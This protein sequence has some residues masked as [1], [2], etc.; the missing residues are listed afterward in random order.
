M[1]C[2][3]VLVYLLVTW[4]G[5]DLIKQNQERKKRSKDEKK[6]KKKRQL[7]EKEVELQRN[8]GKEIAP[9]AKAEEDEPEKEPLKN[10]DR[11]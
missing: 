6:E 8:G 11:T 10:G 9:V 7:A 1:A 3:T 2:V 5:R 4:F